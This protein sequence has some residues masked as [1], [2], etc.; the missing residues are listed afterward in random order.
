MVLRKLFAVALLG[1]SCGVTSHASAEPL[2]PPAK[3]T[4]HKPTTHKP[5]THKPG[6]HKPAPGKTTPTPPGNTLPA[7]PTLPATPP[8][9]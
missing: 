2:A 7:K 4:T 3:G 6:T 8:P 9:L 5:A 1:V